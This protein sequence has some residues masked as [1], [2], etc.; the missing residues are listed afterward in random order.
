MPLRNDIHGICPIVISH[1]FLSFLLTLL[2]KMYE[3]L[4]GR[5]VRM[6]DKDLKLK[7]TL[8]QHCELTLSVTI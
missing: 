1:L 5:I 7:L 3:T 8:V 4:Q 2:K 6:V